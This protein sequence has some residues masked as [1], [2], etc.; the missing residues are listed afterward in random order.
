MRLDELFAT[1]LHHAPGDAH[2]GRVRRHFGHHHRSRADLTV[3]ADGDRP[4]DLGA[5]ADHDVLAQCRVPF[6]FLHAG[7][8]ESHA[9]IQ[10]AVSADF[11]GFADH[12]AHAV[13]DEQPRSDVRSGMDLDACEETPDMGD[14]A[15][16]DQPAMHPQPMCQTME[17]QGMHTGVTPQDLDDAPCRGITLNTT[18]T[19]RFNVSNIAVFPYPGPQAALQSCAESRIPVPGCA[20]SPDVP[21]TIVP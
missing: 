2:H 16:Q 9:L 13:I 12:H 19:S 8:A 6:F 17:E 1:A 7:A 15:S 10:R 18:W 11:G 21:L 3:I 14:K 5:G 20:E 4:E